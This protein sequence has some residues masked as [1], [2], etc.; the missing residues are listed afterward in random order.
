M[1]PDCIMGTDMQFSESGDLVGVRGYF[2]GNGYLELSSYHNPAVGDKPELPE[3]ISEEFKD[4]LPWLQKA[5]ATE[6]QTRL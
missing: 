4:Y 5:V 3:K 1:P 2:R 6:A